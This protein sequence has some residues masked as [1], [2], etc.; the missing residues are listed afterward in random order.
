MGNWVNLRGKPI[1]FQNLHRF[2]SWGFLLKNFLF[3][4]YL[5]R[6]HHILGI[7]WCVLW[8]FSGYDEFY[9]IIQNHLF[10]KHVKGWCNQSS[11]IFHPQFRITCERMMQSIKLYFPSPIQDNIT[12]CKNIHEFITHT[13][14]NMVVPKY[15]G[16][17]VSS[18]LS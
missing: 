12:K 7:L 17:E 18:E 2:S 13:N 4:F 11:Y 15:R 1:W 14:K 6:Y 8:L 10:L 16:L 9:I 3:D 5:S